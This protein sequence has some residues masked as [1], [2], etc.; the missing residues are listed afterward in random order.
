MPGSGVL[1]HLKNM[2]V[3]SEQDLA[4]RRAALSAALGRVAQGDRGALQQVYE[5][6]SSKLLGTILHVLR[7][8]DRAEDVLQEVYLKVWHRAGRFD[9]S[10]ASPI[11]WLCAIARNA[12]IDR[13]RKDGRNLEDDA[14]GAL[15]DVED[16]SMGADDALCRAED[17]DALRRCL[18]GLEKDHRKSIRLAFFRGLT[19]SELADRVGVP[20]GTMKSWI[21][22]GLKNLKGCL[23][24]G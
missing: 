10:R 5:A 19:H 20:L 23:A 13:V 7:D 17:R 2:G 22:R 21:R 1:L 16:D 4:E 8:R 3:A 15:P 12:A 9:E 6:T 18:E 14:S 11:T 24:D